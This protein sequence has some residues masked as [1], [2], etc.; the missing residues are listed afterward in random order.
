MA[1]EIFYDSYSI[2]ALPSCPYC[3]F[4]QRDPRAR[5]RKNISTRVLF[6]FIYSAIN[7]A[8]PV[9]EAA[10]SFGHR[11]VTDKTLK[12]LILSQMTRVTPLRGLLHCRRSA[13]CKRDNKRFLA[14]SSHQAVDCFAYYLLELRHLRHFR[15]FAT[16]SM[17]WP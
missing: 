12:T 10:P 11:S 13:A 5:R 9:T 2:K 1:L 4:V 14:N 7:R 6:S 15:H 16:T 17:I 8:D 3:I